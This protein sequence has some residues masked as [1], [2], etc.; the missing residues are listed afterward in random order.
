MEV[1][2]K[3]MDIVNGDIA[4]DL[5]DTAFSLSGRY[6]VVSPS[7]VVDIDSTI[8]TI[9][10]KP[11][12]SYGVL[13]LTKEV[14]K[15]EQYIGEAVVTHDE[16]WTTLDYGVISGID[17]IGD[18]LYVDG[19]SSAPSEN[20]IIDLHDYDSQSVK[21]KRIHVFLNPLLKVTSGTSQTVFDANVPSLLYVGA[22][23]Q[24]NNYDYSRKSIEVLVTDITGS[25]IT[26]DTALGFIP[27][28]DDE[29]NLIGHVIDQSVPYRYV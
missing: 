16:N 15:W 23:I 28:V 5:L 9:Y 12:Y 18:A 22:I 19:L 24:V 25:T 7:S 6:G 13:E 26:V 14:Q 1:V 17:E 4:L 20:S 10:L 3:S 11:S 8:A 29:I 2:N 21:M 27:Q